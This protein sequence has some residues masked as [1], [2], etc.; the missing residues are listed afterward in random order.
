MTPEINQNLFVVAIKLAAVIFALLHMGAA[1]ALFRQVV[2][3]NNKVRTSSSG[4]LRLFALTH[5]LVL[6]AIVL[7]IIFI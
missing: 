7:L 1:L 5:I 6:A 4:C 3:M 2:T